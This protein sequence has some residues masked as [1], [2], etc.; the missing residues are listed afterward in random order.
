MNCKNAAGV[1][2]CGCAKGAEIPVTA[3]TLR[4]HFAACALMQL[5]VDIGERGYDEQAASRDAYAIADAM[6]A[7]RAKG[8]A[9]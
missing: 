4:D 9:K 1:E 7:E 3:M 2:A 5:V 6:L 8:G